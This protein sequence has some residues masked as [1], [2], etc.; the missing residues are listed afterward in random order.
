MVSLPP[1]SAL[2]RYR[3]VE[4]LGKGGMATVFRCHDPNLDRYVAVKVLPSY[5]TEDPTF[6]GRFRQEAQTIAKLSHPNILQ[7]YDFGDD[8][9][10]T[11]I[12]SELVLGGD[13]QDKLGHEAMDLDGVVKYMAPLSEALD[14]AHAQG[15]VHRD[16]KPANVLIDTEDRPI[17]ADFGLARMLESTQRFT[18][19]SQALGTPE[20]M[21]PE[22]AMGAD[23]DHRSDLYA[24]GIMVYQMLLGETPFRAET[25]A[26]TLMAHVHKPLPLP[27]VVNPSIEPMLEA[28]LLKSLAKEPDDRFQSARGLIQALAT[29]Q[30]EEAGGLDDSGATAV[31]D[32]SALDEAG[33]MA[34]T[35]IMG[36]P[37]SE[38]ATRD[39]AAPAGPGATAGT[40]RAEPSPSGMPGW[41]LPAAVAAGVAV[42]AAVGGLVLLSGDK[43]D[44]ATVPSAG[45]PAQDSAP[46]EAAPE[47]E[48]QMSVAEALAKLQGMTDDAKKNVAELRKVELALAEGA[49]LGDVEIEFVTR[50]QLESITKG[51]FKREVLRQQIFEA[52]ELYKTLGLMEEDQEL[53]LPPLTTMRKG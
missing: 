42:I 34:Q 43:A 29:G 22:Q 18:Q 17:L 15:I 8:K 50:E 6:I 1:G 51:F 20:Y 47:P 40:P 37:T 44:K 38:A 46:Q 45:A 21:A 19:A 52:N 10:F 9:G 12:V 28:T 4:Q 48:P 30:T 3:V 27:S 23:A 36:Q 25:P 41:L 14:Y 11:Y 5:M 35:A 49:E 32:T 39:I 53:E 26:A 33:D 31:L 13:L 2:G 16:L 7:I 24:L